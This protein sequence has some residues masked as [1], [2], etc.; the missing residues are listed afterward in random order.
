MS[1]ILKVVDLPKSVYFYYQNKEDS[2][3]NDQELID[4]IKVIKKENPAYGYRRVT[5]E[6]KNRGLEGQSQKSSTCYAG[7]TLTITSLHEEKQ[8]I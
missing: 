3:Q 4:E 1:E 8:K 2:K 6:L 7:A 5:L